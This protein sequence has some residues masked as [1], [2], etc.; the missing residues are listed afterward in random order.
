M[1]SPQALWQHQPMIVNRPTA[2]ARGAPTALALLCL[3]GCA[4]PPPETIGAVAMA[5]AP[6][7][8]NDWQQPLTAWANR[9]C[10]AH[11][12]SAT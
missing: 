4:E 5:E 3:T 7:V 10:G 9:T 1:D 12:R 8:A 11:G 6:A 2:Q